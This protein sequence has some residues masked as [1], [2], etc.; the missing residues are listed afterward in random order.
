MS[1]A[2]PPKLKNFVDKKLS[3]K[4]NG[5]RHI[6]GILQGFESFMNPVTDECV[7]MATNGQQNNIEMVVIPGNS[8]IMLEAFERVSRMA[9]EIAQDFKTDLHFQSAAIGTLQEARE[10]YLV[11]LFENTNLCAISIPNM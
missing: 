1:K 2:T 9:Q 6:Q 10:A 3:L 8:I 11:G 7:K 4:L 5:G